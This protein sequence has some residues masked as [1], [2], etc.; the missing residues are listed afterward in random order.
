MILVGQMRRQ[1]P[2]RGQ[3]ER[4]RFEQ[5]ED[6]RISS[7]RSTRFDAVV[8]AALGQVQLLR[9][10]REHRRIAFAEIQAPAVDLRQRPKQGDGGVTFLAGQPLCHLEQRA[11]AE[12]SEGVFRRH[13]SFYHGV[14]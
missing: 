8:G 6:D 9:A 13:S 2:D 11:I 12:V 3:R 1:Q 14:S 5:V 7:R 10:I 4:R